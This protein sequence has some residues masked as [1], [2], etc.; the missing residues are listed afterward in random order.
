M[1]GDE[2]RGKIVDALCDI[3]PEID[4]G[5]VAD[6]TDLRE[7][8]DLDSMDLLTFFESLEERFHVRIPEDQASSIRTFGQVVGQVTQ[9]MKEE[10]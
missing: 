1:T 8:L 3:A 2:L 7:D 10:E 9:R 4:P 5:D 6:G